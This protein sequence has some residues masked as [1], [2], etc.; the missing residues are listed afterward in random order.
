MV[1][2]AELASKGEDRSVNVLCQTCLRRT[3]HEILCEFEKKEYDEVWGFSS[4]DFFQIVRCRGCETVS[5]R[6]AET[7]DIDEDPQTGEPI[8][9]EHVYPYR[10]AGRKKMDGSERLPLK[11]RK[12]YEETHTALAANASILGTIGIRAVVEAVCKDKNT[13]GSTLKERID[14]LAAKGLLAT[15][16][17]QFLHQNR[18]VGNVAVHEIEP[19]DE[20]TLKIALDIIE[21]LLQTVYLLPA[22]L[23]QGKP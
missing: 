4:Y 18:L 10:L 22:A 1:D 15:T 17:A 21:N 6:T 13:V 2:T 23:A 12:I 11:V 8:L 5:F 16:Q 19:A 7:S 3:K 20:A 14:D 9:T